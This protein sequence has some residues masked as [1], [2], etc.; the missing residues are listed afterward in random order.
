ME[1]EHSILV[2][3]AVLFGVP[4]LYVVILAGVVWLE[5][6]PRREVAGDAAS[7]QGA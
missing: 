5:L 3:R 1:G 6:R 4:L 2:R 7:L